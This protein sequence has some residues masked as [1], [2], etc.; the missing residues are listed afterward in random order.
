MAKGRKESNKEIRKPQAE[1]PKAGRRAEA[2]R[3]KAIARWE[4]EGGAG[5]CGPQMAGPDESPMRQDRR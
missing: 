4:N 1:K 3:R 5:P 2:Q